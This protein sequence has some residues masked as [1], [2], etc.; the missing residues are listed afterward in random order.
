MKKKNKKIVILGIDPG[1]ATTGYALLEKEA[2]KLNVLDF[3]VIKTSSSLNFPERIKEIFQKTQKLIKKYSPQILVIEKVFFCKNVKTA[4]KIGQVQG[5]FFLLAA[6]KKIPL[7]QFTPLQVKQVITSYGKA[8]KKQLQ[9]MIKIL[10][11][12]KEIPKPNDA[13]DALATAYCFLQNKFREKGT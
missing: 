2:K 13:A 11:N 4:I 10:L 8:D 6:Q 3:G 7:Y 5:I 9:K 12:L 1:L